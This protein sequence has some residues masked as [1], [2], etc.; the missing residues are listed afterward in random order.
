MPRPLWIP[1]LAALAGAAPAQAATLTI[2]CTALGVEQE[3]CQ[4]GAQRWAAA[5][6]HTIELVNPPQSASE[7]LA[8]YL[9]LLNAGSSDIDVFQIDVIWPGMLASHL[10]D[11][12]PYLEPGLL[13]LHLPAAAGGVRRGDAV[14]AL[15]WFADAP[16]LYY[17]R[18]LLDAYGLEVPQ[19]W[20]ALTAAARHIQDG[21]RD[22]GAARFWGF[23][24]QGR[25]YEGLT[26]NALEWVASHGGGT[27]VDADGRVTLDSPAAAAALEQAASWVGTISPE[28][29]LN[30]ME[31]DARAV[32]QSGNAAFMRN[33]PYAY[34]LADAADSPIR[35]R[36]AVAPLPAGPDGRRAATLGGQNLAVSRYSAHPDLAVDLVVYLTGIEEQRRRAVEGSFAPTVAALYDD[37]DVLASAPFMPVF[38]DVLETTVARPAAVAGERYNEA[39]A[40]IFN[41]VHAAL[42]GQGDAQQL[43]SAADRD[44]LRLSRG[45]RW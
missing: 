12:A 11:L 13:D 16:L 41:A 44:L 24:W 14:L 21:E 42:A 27:F 18:D 15:P 25:A 17:R 39:S 8:L 43:L 45:G 29:V 1:V 26:C 10:L 6:G 40:V 5:T 7:Q 38:A 19:T 9:Q 3:L 36:F 28:G 34:A 23:V 4:E 22:A 2:A 20:E 37:A 33:W 31:E 35:G 30:Y 32:F